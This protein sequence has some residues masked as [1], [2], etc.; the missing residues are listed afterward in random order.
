MGPRLQRII[1]EAALAAALFSLSGK[2]E[3]DPDGG[4]VII[5]DFPLPDGFIY[6]KDEKTEKAR[7]T[8]ILILL[9][10]DY[11]KTPPDWFYMDPTLRREKDNQ[12]PQH[13]FEQWSERL[14][15]QDPRQKGWAA[16]CVHI[17][18]NWRP[19]SNPLTGHSLLTVC[20]IIRETFERWL[21]Q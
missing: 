11:P 17:R 3:V 4:W 8:S 5:H 2:A 9:P 20:R 6:R 15:P 13:Y 7:S 12:P 10:A 21:R 14:A 1:K 19:S 18:G 16:G